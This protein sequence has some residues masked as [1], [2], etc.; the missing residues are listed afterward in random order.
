[1]HKRPCF[2][3]L[4]TK[5]KSMFSKRFAA[6]LIA[7]AVTAL[8]SVAA[9]AAVTIDVTKA[10]IGPDGITIHSLQK[11]TVTLA[12]L[13]NSHPLEESNVYGFKVTEST[14]GSNF[15]AMA[16][17]FYTFCTDIAD[18]F[19]P[20][21]NQYTVEANGSTHGFSLADATLMAKLFT[22]AGFNSLN[23]FGAGNNTVL[24]FVSMQMAV[25][26]VLYD[27]DLTVS[28]GTFQLLT[29]NNVGARAQANSWLTAAGALNSANLQVHNLHSALEQDIVITSVPEPSAYALAL[30]AALGLGAVAR[31]RAKA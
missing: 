10:N 24:N 30:M 25:W 29:D 21:P 15:Q 1:M 23:G 7:T 2:L 6:S 11:E 8:G 4:I 14:A 16:G 27:T 9:T 12:G 5:G 19:H 13:T 20:L 18:P 28:G 3:G 31:R 26:N 22:T 17:S